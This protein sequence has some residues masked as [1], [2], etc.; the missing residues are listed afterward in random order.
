M[1]QPFKYHCPFEAGIA[2]IGG[3]WKSLIIWQLRSGTL[4]F[5]QLIERM[6]MVSPRM[7]TK[8]LRELEED[9]VVVRRMYPEIPP[10]VEYSLS[11][12]GMAVVPV[13][14]SLCTWGSDY[15]LRNGSTTYKK[16]GNTDIT[17]EKKN[18]EDI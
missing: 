9:G 6:P 4:R 2:V 3:K 17:E 7:L 16:S 14:E 13:L 8:Q 12:L 11:D 1:K 18:P 15:L 5:T 10:R